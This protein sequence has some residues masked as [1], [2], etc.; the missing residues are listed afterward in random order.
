MPQPG[1]AD[2]ERVLKPVNSRLV[3]LE[4][5]FEAHREDVREERDDGF[6]NLGGVAASNPGVPSLLASGGHALEAAKSMVGAA[7][8]KAKAIGSRIVVLRFGEHTIERH[9]ERHEELRARL[10]TVGIDAETERLA[11]A[12]LVDLGRR[13]EVDTER[14][15]RNLFDLTKAEP[16]IRFAVATPETFAGF[17]C[18]RALGLLLDE[19][20]G[21]NI[22]YFH[23]VACAHLHEKAGLAAPHSFAGDYGKSIVGVAAHDVAGTEIYFPPGSGELD[24][25][26]IR[27]NLPSGVP[28]VLEIDSRF[29]VKETQ[30][31]ASLLKSAGY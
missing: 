2:L 17:P 14:A 31:A 30:L 27:E 3:A 16:E 21:K 15:C 22:G 13:V 5:R 29:S 1:S 7:A 11:R 25:K 4:F 8:A 26:V 18:H 23:D 28:T 9:R 20:Q 19:L 6:R 12:L 10:T 24:F